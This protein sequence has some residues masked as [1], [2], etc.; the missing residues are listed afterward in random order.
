MVLT[1]V[2]N[3][4]IQD[5]CR[6]HLQFSTDSSLQLGLV[7]DSYSL[8]L[9]S[10]TL[11]SYWLAFLSKTCIKKRFLLNTVSITEII[12]NIVEIILKIKHRTFEGLLVHENN[13]PRIPKNIKTNITKNNSLFLREIHL[14]RFWL[15][16]ESAAFL[17]FSDCCFSLSDNNCFWYF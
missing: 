7:S 15:A 9:F 14:L 11:V 13:T 12:P 10:R 2:G 17:F 16:Y 8:N 3:P 6:E 4:G 1:Y 5:P